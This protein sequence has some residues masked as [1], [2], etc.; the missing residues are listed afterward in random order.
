MVHQQT[1]RD[2]RCVLVLSSMACGLW[3]GGCAS[4]PLRSSYVGPQPLP[5]ALAGYYDYPSTPQEGTIELVNEHPR[6]R[7]FLVKFPFSAPDFEPTEPTIEIEWFESTAGGRRPAILFNPILGG[8]YPLERGVC[9]FFA[10]NGFHVALIHRKTVK[11]SP[12]HRVDHLELLL[13]QTLM[14]IRQV[15]DWMEAHERVDPQ[16]MGS[17]GIS[18]GGMASVM[19]AAI[20]PRL[21]AHVAALAGGSIPDVLMTSRDRLLTKPRRRYLE[22]NEMDLKTMDRL[23]RESV[24]TDPLLLAPYADSRRILMFITLADRTVGTQ[25]ELRLRRALGYPRTEFL[26]AGHYTAYLFL[27]YLQYASLRFLKRQLAPSP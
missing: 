15:V 21:R 12:E 14:R 22:R 10:R 16:R 19:A 23:L 17:F 11:L 3:T 2:L 9:R 13:R 27:P 8:D 24:K 20:E 18:M 25:N 4:A 26:L 1:F 6:F 5:A 7:T